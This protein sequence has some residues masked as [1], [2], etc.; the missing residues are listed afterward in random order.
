MKVRSTVFGFC[1]IISTGSIGVGYFLAGYWQILPGL[2]VLLFMG[3]FRKKLK[4][5]WSSSSYLLAFVVL[6]AIGVIIGVSVMLMILACTAAL[7]SWDLWH[8]E[9]DLDGNTCSKSSASFQQYHLRSLAFA[10]STGLVLAILSANISLH[11]TFGAIIPL[12]LIAVG[13]LIYGMEYI[14]KKKR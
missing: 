10:S 13:G 4:V 7:A 12:V 9:Q 6:A 2:L 1:S 8:L 5:V 3:I 11:L 14:G